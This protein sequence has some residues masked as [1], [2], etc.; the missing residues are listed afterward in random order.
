MSYAVV[1]YFPCIRGQSGLL[2]TASP[3]A[4]SVS[5]IHPLKDLTTFLERYLG[6]QL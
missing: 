3:C 4:F 1:S 6:E 2:C 5:V